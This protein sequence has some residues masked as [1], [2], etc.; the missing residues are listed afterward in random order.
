M[1]HIIL[2]I[3]I[4]QFFKF[5]AKVLFRIYN[6][7]FNDEI[8]ALKGSDCGV[9]FQNAD[10]NINMG[11]WF[12]DPDI[13][14]DDIFWYNILAAQI[15]MSLKDGNGLISIDEELNTR[16]CYVE[17]LRKGDLESTRFIFT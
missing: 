1:D 10:G 13:E 12:N 15:E 2:S 11:V 7:G 17:L 4:D 9:L 16:S 5:V 3:Y 14:L 8:V 6:S